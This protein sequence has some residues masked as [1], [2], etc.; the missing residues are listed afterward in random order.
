MTSPA[1]TT[2]PPLI[3]VSYPLVSSSPPVPAALSKQQARP[4]L[5][6]PPDFSGEQ[7]SGWAFF[8]S[9]T[10]YLHLAPEQFS[11]NKK[12][13]F[14]TLTFKDRRAVRQSE[15]LFCQEV[16]TSIF[17]IQFW[18][19]FELQF[20]SQFFPVNAKANTINT[21]KGSLYYQENQTV[22]NYL[23]SFLIL[24][25]DAG[26]TDPW[27]LVVKFC[28]G[29]KLN[30]QS[31]ITTMPFGRPADTD[32]EAWYTATQRINQ[33]QLANKAFQSMLW[34]MNLAP[35]YSALPQS[36]PLSI[37]HPL[38][39]Q[40]PLYLHYLKEYPQMQMQFG[41]RALYLYAGAIGAE[42][43]TIL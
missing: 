35:M 27:T 41:K 21:L 11:Y 13:I 6:S 36:T 42:R 22:D 28:Q 3:P 20:Q 19:D 5:P 15:N 37:F 32:P 30:I 34:S 18:T 33:A 9:C 38:F 25:L 23:N 24:T 12:K 43:P 10:L 40:G 26:Y 8:N 17:P 1:L 39:H 31:Q 7:S 16:D 2:A 14:Q 29:L 4:K